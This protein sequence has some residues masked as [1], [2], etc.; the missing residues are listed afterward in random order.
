MD[1]NH[2]RVGTGFRRMDAAVAV[3]V[4]S[5]FGT[6]VF[7]AAVA[8]VQWPP[9]VQSVSAADKPDT[10]PSAAALVQ[11]SVLS[12]CAA[13]CPV[14]V[15]AGELSRGVVLASLLKTSAL[16]VPSPASL[17]EPRISLEN[18]RRRK[19]IN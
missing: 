8:V 15:L 11:V 14:L 2:P 10:Q 17:E 7:V 5:V 18:R 4:A 1:W 19:L 9:V 6:G 13:A 16:H 3:A 12:A